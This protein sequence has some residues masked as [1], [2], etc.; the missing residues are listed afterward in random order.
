MYK[1][2]ESEACIII[3]LFVH[4]VELALKKTLIY[5]GFGYFRNVDFIMFSNMF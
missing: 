4:I 1:I 5:L 3:P 2:T